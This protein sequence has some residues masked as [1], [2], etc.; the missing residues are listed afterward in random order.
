MASIHRRVHI[1]ALVLDEVQKIPAWPETVKRLWDEDTRKWRPLKV[2][3]LGSAPL[4]I[5]QG[6]FERVAGRFETLRL[7]HWSFSEMRAAVAITLDQYLY[8]GG[9]RQLQ[10]KTPPDV[11]AGLRVSTRCSASD[12]GVSRQDIDS[13]GVWLGEVQPSYISSYR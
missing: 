13:F 10:A 3:L 2:G 1:A 4:L 5:A 7:L 11:Y 6:L 8:F 12:R 9:L